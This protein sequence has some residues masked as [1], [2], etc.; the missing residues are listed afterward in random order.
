MNDNCTDSSPPST[1]EEIL[2]EF[3]EVS[4]SLL[5]FCSG[6][7]PL[8]PPSAHRGSA[9]TALLSQG[10]RGAGCESAAFPG[11]IP[12]RRQLSRSSLSPHRSK[13]VIVRKN[14]QT[15]TRAAADMP[16]TTTARN[17]NK[18]L[19]HSRC[20]QNIYHRLREI[21]R[22]DRAT[23]S[24]RFQPPFH[25]GMHGAAKVC[26]LAPPSAVIFDLDRSRRR[27]Q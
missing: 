8:P 3:L 17:F 6:P 21:T 19:P 20:H 15:G 4:L 1:A 18:A 7:T 13:R 25:A 12:L 9:A 23:W 5:C 2:H 10:D 11:G 27:R 14:E 22:A 16:T 26:L 24:S